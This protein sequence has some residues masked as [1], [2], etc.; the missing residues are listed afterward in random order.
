[1]T[2][3][4]FLAK[5]FNHKNTQLLIGDAANARDLGVDEKRYMM[6]INSSKNGLFYPDAENNF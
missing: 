3:Q 5:V 2:L 1:M 6:L 4:F